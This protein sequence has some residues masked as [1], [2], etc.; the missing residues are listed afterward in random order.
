MGRPDKIES[1]LLNASALIGVIKAE[2]EFE[3]LKSLLAAVDRGEV[4]A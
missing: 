4:R 2:P 1:V 3:C